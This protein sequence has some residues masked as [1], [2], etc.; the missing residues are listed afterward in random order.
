[1]D[2]SAARTQVPRGR[3]GRTLARTRPYQFAVGVG[4]NSRADFDDDALAL[5]QLLA[6]RVGLDH[7]RSCSERM[8]GLKEGTKAMRPRGPARHHRPQARVR[9]QRAPA[10]AWPLPLRLRDPQRDAKAHGPRTKKK[11]SA[12]KL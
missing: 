5:K 3:D 12:N 8:R 11:D 6:V 2:T 4:H 1:M 9:F 7:Q 10:P